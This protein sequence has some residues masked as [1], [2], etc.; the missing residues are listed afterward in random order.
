MFNNLIMII[1]LM[2][3]VGQL[4]VIFMIVHAFR[5]TLAAL[6]EYFDKKS[7]RAM[8]FATEEN[9][10]SKKETY[11]ALQNAWEKAKEV[12]EKELERW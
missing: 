12:T 5:K 10:E 8:K 6:T 9:D 1:M 4:L 7:E 3:F 11:R 2:I